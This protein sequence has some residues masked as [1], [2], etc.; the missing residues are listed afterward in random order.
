MSFRKVSQRYFVSQPSISKSIGNLEA[1]LD[2]RLFDR[3][4]DGVH[5]TAE[6]QALLPYA[7]QM[8]EILKTAKARI[9]DVRSSDKGIVRIACV[10][11]ATPVLSECLKASITRYPKIYVDIILVNGND[12]MA[13]L[14][15]EQFDFTFGCYNNIPSSSISEVHLIREGHL[16]LI[17]PRA[18]YP[19]TQKVRLLDLTEVPFIAISP[20]TGPLYEQILRCCKNRGLNPHVVGFF[21]STQTL[22]IAVQAGAGISVLPPE[23][24]RDLPKDDVT[25]IPF[26]G[27]DARFDSY[28]SWK[29][30]SSN[31][32]AEKF[33]QVIK[34]MLNHEC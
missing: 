13:A 17:L 6:G 33:L 22:S 12:Q 32:A 10:H 3:K 4:S 26:D 2:A 21:D 11:G 7:V 28:I 29:K 15:D 25:V 19:D 30:S 5:L 9:R 16:C 8:D 18:Q 14:D 27:E 23:L 31:N 34:E 1:E 20:S 24:A